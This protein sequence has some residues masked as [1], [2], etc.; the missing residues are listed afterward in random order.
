MLLEGS[1]YGVG[2]RNGQ[3]G[4]YNLSLTNP[5]SGLLALKFMSMQIKK[6]V[7]LVCHRNQGGQVSD[8]LD[9]VSCTFSQEEREGKFSFCRATE[10]A[11]ED[12]GSLDPAQSISPQD[13]TMWRDCTQ[14]K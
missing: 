3:S 8:P 14:L 7:V 12:G 2:C 1:F 4:A 5:F 13:I 6:K 11:R 9:A 10:A